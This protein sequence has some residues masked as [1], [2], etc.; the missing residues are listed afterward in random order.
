MTKNNVETCTKFNKRAGTANF[1][2]FPL[3]F[4]GSGPKWSKPMTPPQ[5]PKSAIT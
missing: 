4:C 5:P 2:D 1:T 3:I